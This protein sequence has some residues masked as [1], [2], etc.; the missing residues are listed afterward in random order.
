MAAGYAGVAFLVH[1]PFS[2][3]SELAGADAILVGEAADDFT[4]G[5]VAALGDLD[6]DG[7]A[8]FLINA[9][10]NDAGGTEAGAV[11]V[12]LG[13]ASGQVPLA[14]AD[15]W[16]GEEPGDHAG[17]QIA[18]AGDVNGDGAPDFLVGAS[19]HGAGGEEAGAAY[20]I[21]GGS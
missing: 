9:S 21:L 10:Q 16:V 3:V 18:A 2:G 19:T 4:G 11:F 14:S 5:D 1:G 8:D 12:V 15:R 13:P 20:L 6:G 17:N 7:V